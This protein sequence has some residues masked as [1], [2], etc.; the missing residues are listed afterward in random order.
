MQIILIFFEKKKV[1]LTL[2]YVRSNYNL[3]YPKL[4]GYKFNVHVF[5]QISIHAQY[6]VVESTQILKI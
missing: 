3:A 5:F 2:S 4:N 6:I 1:Q